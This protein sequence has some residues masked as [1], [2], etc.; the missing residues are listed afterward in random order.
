[1]FPSM[2]KYLRSVCTLALFGALPACQSTSPA[3]GPKE[4]EPAAAVA[5]VEPAKPA[6]PAPAQPA[7]AQGQAKPVPPTEP[8]STPAQPAADADRELAGAAPVTDSD[9]FRAMVRMEGAMRDCPPADPEFQA[10]VATTFDAL[11]RGTMSPRRD[12]ALRAMNRLRRE[13]CGDTAIDTADAAVDSL[14]VYVDPMVTTVPE[15]LKP[16]QPTVIRIRSQYDPGVTLAQPVNVRL[17]ITALDDDKPLW[18]HDVPCTFRAGETVDIAVPVDGVLPFEG[19]GK[20]YRVGLV[21]DGRFWDL[22][23]WTVVR[24][25]MPTTANA[26]LAEIASL[27]QEPVELSRAAGIARSRT[28]MLAPEPNEEDSIWFTADFGRLIQSLTQRELPALKKGE[29]PYLGLSGENMLPVQLASMPGDPVL[30]VVYAPASLPTET[31]APLVIVMNAPYT[32]EG[33]FFHGYGLGD[34]RR[35]ADKH[36]F[37]VASI[38]GFAAQGS[39]QRFEPVVRQMSAHYRIDASR[40]YLLGHSSGGHAALRMSGMY[41]ESVAAMAAFAP[42][43]YIVVRE[44][45][46][47]PFPPTLIYASDADK[48][49]PAHQVKKWIDEA[50]AEQGL[51]IE[52]RPLSG[53]SHQLMVQAHL[54][55][56]IEWLLEHKL[57]N[58]VFPPQTPPQ[59]GK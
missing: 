24:A 17:C 48:I 11:V 21:R 13:I 56:A 41:S 57:E 18:T 32:D 44:G 1:M 42:G 43:G 16:A 40:I 39:P 31:G 9:T 55:E 35:L 46:T 14:K 4:K 25:P 22:S 58:P 26:L 34:I 28:I 6:E 15:G 53:E 51:A 59:P 3:P 54:A 12:L 30:C 2:T 7:P 52:Y 47:R 5:A 50:I 36:G 33:M 45:A 49:I 23:R 29:N 19:P 10:R 27:P 37:I 38:R 8:T 20:T